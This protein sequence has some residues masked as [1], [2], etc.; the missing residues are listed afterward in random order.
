MPTPRPP[1]PPDPLSGVRLHATLRFAVGTTGSLVLCE[2]FTLR[3]TF[4]VP[5]LT[6]ALLANLP[7]RPPLKLGLTLT[8]VM[9]IAAL[10]TFVMSSLLL[11]MPQVLFVAIALCMFLAFLA[12]LRGGPAFPITLFLLCLA[13][14]PVVAMAYPA[15]AELLPQAMALGMGLDFLVLL[16]V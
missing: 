5:L 9:A 6:G 14:V 8:I 4:V 3:P 1:T 10:F 7:G 2:M 16:L 15:D 12:M 13:T 11:D